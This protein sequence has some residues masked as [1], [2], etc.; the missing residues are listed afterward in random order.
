MTN[1][2][3]LRVWLYS[4]A[5]L[6]GVIGLCMLLRHMPGPRYDN[7]IASQTQTF[8]ATP[9]S[10]EK[11]RVL[12]L[13]SSL[14]RAATPEVASVQRAAMPDIAWM[15]MTKGGG[16][17]GYLQASLA[18]LVSRPPDVLILEQNL[19]LPDDGNMA[20]D[21]L[22]EDAW[23]FA[24][25]TVS[26]LTAGKFSSPPPYWERNDQEL[27]FTCG[28]EQ[29]TFSVAQMRQHAVSLQDLYRQSTFD[30]ALISNVA[31][32]AQRGVR[33]VLLDVRRSLL[34]EQLTAQ[35]KEDWQR[36]L[37]ALLP[38]SRNIIYLTSPAFTRQNL[39]CDGSHLNAQGA[40]LFG[41]WWQSQLQQLR[42]RA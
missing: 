6:A 8:L 4:A 12:A 28:P 11:L 18:T 29:R 39:Y 10:G 20:M 24:K 37:H 22:R 27:A 13:G 25:Q 3:P 2:P 38:A 40:R 19:L 7:T 30:A 36:R 31:A 41:P 16:G 42:N 32:L 35:Q 17:M 5:L 33:V 26:L 9:S 34:M 23:H 15:R 14:L 21:E 1:A